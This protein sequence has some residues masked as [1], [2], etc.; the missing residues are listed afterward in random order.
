[1]PSL[2]HHAPPPCSAP[3]PRLCDCK[4]IGDAVRAG[5]GTLRD[6]EEQLAFLNEYIY[7]VG[8]GLECD[9]CI[10]VAVVVRVQ[11]AFLNEYIYTVGGLHVTG[12]L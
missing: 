5:R 9:L 4:R 11:L 8:G 7:K 6:I 2:S 1:M 10:L 12:L 3:A